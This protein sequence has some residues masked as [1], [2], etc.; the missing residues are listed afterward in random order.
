MAP[1]YI[2]GAVLLACLTGGHRAN[3]LIAGHAGHKNNARKLVRSHAN[4]VTEYNYAQFDAMADYG[5]TW[6][7][8]TWAS[9]KD[10]VASFHLDDMQLPATTPASR[11]IKTRP[12]PAGAYDTQDI[13][14][15]ADYEK[16][17][18]IVT[19]MAPPRFSTRMGPEEYAS[20]LADYSEFVR[21]YTGREG[22]YES[23]QYDV[24][25][26]YAPLAPAL[27]APSRDVAEQLGSLCA[28]STGDLEEIADYV[29]DYC[30]N[31]EE[32][33]I[34]AYLDE[35]CIVASLSKE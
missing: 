8:A 3:A 7:E 26:D 18:K 11:G 25:A 24:V 20:F 22:V 35:E 21:P 17:S 32:C 5:S 13:D 14:M 33:A 29:A 31:D 30:G 28:K 2:A 12:D 1:T 23:S 6:T 9:S 19:Y 34:N 15:H 4:G 27:K 16:V 10:A